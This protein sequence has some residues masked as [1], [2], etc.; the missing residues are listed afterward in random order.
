MKESFVT[1]LSPVGLE[2]IRRN[3][4][5]DR[6]MASSGLKILSQGQNVTANPPEIIHRSV[7]FVGC[8]SQPQH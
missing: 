1:R 4:F 7:Q 5:N 8:F 3:E 6:Q 2:P